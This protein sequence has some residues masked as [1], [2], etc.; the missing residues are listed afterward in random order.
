MKIEINVNAIEENKPNEYEQIDYI[1]YD[2]H[3]PI[4]KYNIYGKEIF[5]KREDLFLASYQPLI[6]GLAKLR[7]ARKLL[8]KLNGNDIK[9]IAVFDTRI[10]KAGQGISFLCKELK[11]E[12]AVGFPLLKEQEKLGILDERQKISQM[13]GAKLIPMK[14]G[15]TAVCYAQFKNKMKE[16]GY[17]VLPLGLTCHETVE[18]VSVI[19]SRIKHVKTIVLSTGTGTIATGVSIG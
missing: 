12:C 18:E 5:V 14:A 11:L 17:A 1:Y 10:S 16:E 13:L 19:S 7:G 2:E 4:E 15:R 6:P 9:K 3:T 8:T